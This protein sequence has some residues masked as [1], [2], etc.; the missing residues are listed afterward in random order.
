MKSK[1]LVTVAILS[2]L[3]A[4]QPEIPEAS[5]EQLADLLGGPGSAYDMPLISQKAVECLQLISGLAD[6]VF[7]DAPKE[8]IAYYKTGCRQD[9]DKRLRDTSRNPL[10]FK[11]EHFENPD[12]AERVSN[13]RD[14]Q[15]KIIADK[16]KEEEQERLA[17]KQQ[18][19]QERVQQTAK[20]LA[21]AKRESKQ[22]LAYVEMWLAQMD[23]KCTGL[24]HLNDQRKGQNISV[25]LTMTSKLLG[26]CQDYTFKNIREDAQKT[27]EKI[28]ELTYDS[29]PNTRLFIPDF[30]AASKDN[31]DKYQLETD[32]LYAELKAILDGK[33]N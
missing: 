11:L 8:Q 4:C 27:S 25:P 23:G 22:H 30:A 10:G 7:K 20:R 6:D 28:A 32:E 31:L 17:E 26:S 12:L 15:R 14:A 5:N 29:D 1:A 16:K 18:E 2:I 24:K 13:V 21:D 19:E 9:L 33:A 3:A